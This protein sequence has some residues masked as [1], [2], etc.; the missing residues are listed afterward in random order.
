MY[1]LLKKPAPLFLA[2]LLIISYVFFAIKYFSHSCGASN[3]KCQK[4]KCCKSQEGQVD[5]AHV[6]TGQ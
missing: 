1:N 5:S 2:L 4:K 6:S 3:A